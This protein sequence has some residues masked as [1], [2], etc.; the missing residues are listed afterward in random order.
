MV[1]QPHPNNEK[2]LHSRVMRNARVQGLPLKKYMKEFQRIFF[3]Y[4]IVSHDISLPYVAKKYIKL[5]IG[6]F[7]FNYSCESVKN[8]KM[9]LFL[10]EWINIVTV[11]V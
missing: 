5:F 10:G 9:A 6:T 3:T 11:I 4:S 8:G 1:V 2:R 7:L